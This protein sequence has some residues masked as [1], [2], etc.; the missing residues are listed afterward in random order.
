MTFLFTDIAESRQFWESA[1]S[2]MAVAVRTYDAILR[3]AI[4]RRGGYVFDHEGDGFGAAFSSAVDA[5]LAAVEA[6]RELH[7]NDAIPFA[8][9]MGLHVGEAVAD[10]GSYHGKEVTLASRLTA[11]GHGG[12]VLVSGTAQALVH[13]Q[14]T[15]RPLGD[16]HRRG[17]G[18]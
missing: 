14:V 13:G 10:D 7:D 11:L 5:V 3:S 17:P 18:P 15:L 12:Q 6:Q 2:D 8:V 9:R 1:P 4:E 16:H